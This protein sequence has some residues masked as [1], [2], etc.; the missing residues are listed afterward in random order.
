[1]CEVNVYLQKGNK[2]SLIMEKVFKLEN[3][4]EQIRIENLF[5]EQKFIN[6]SLKEIDFEQNRMIFVEPNNNP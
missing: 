1:M 3:L 6:L 5:G 4:E 2:E